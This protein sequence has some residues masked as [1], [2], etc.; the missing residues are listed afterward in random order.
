MAWISSERKV[1]TTKKYLAEVSSSGAGMINSGAIQCSAQ[2]GFPNWENL[3]GAERPTGSPQLHSLNNS[4]WWDP[5]GTRRNGS[6]PPHTYKRS[7]S[8]QKHCDQDGHGASARLWHSSSCSSGQ[9]CRKDT[10]ALPAQLGS[11]GVHLSE[12]N[13]LSKRCTHHDWY[14]CPDR[15]PGWGAC[16]HPGCRGCPA[17][18]PVLEGSRDHP[19]GTS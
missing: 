16:S 14:C 13:S 5:G 12:S 18:T 2:E 15:A 19:C 6:H 17:V 10:E 4:G 1:I 9:A 7:T 3:S 8:F 11:K